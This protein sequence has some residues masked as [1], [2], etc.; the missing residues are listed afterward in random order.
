DQPPLDASPVSST[1]SSSYALLAALSHAIL[2]DAPVAPGLVVGGTD[3][4][5]YSE[6]AENVYRF[7]PIL[8]TDEDLKGPH[9]IDERLSTAN[10]ERMIRFYIDLM[11]TGAM[12]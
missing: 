1:T 9:G 10:F 2:P 6:A 7:M 3:A 11:E 5:H 8:L 12:Q 4:R